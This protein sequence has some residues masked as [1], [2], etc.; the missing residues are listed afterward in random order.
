MITKTR[1]VPKILSQQAS[2]LTR[3]DEGLSPV[4]KAFS[5][6]VLERAAL[7]KEMIYM[8]IMR[9]SPQRFLRDILKPS[10]RLPIQRDTK[11]WLVAVLTSRCLFGILI[12]KN[13]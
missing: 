3:K 10:E 11:Y 8:M 12:V 4:R 7:V 5:N 1:Q 6:K 9:K 2:L 13:T